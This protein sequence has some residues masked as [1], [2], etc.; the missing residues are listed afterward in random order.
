MIEQSA[1]V[2]SSEAGITEVEMIRRSGCHGCSAQSACGVSLLDRLLGR[3]PQRLVLTNT[4]DVRPGEEVVVGVPE[5][6]LLKAAV[7]AYMVPL[8]GLLA[9]GLVGEQ[10][11]AATLPSEALPLLTG[12]VGLALGLITTRL[13]SRR[14]AHDPRWRAVLL[15]RVSRGLAVGLP[16]AH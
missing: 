5:G 11:A 14:L 16:E 13:Y 4:L 3:R 2:V 9:G 7:V 12:L 8:F 15:R 10:L 1:V 6:A